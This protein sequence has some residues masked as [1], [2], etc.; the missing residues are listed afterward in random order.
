MSRKRYGGWGDDRDRLPFFQRLSTHIGLVIL[1][2]AALFFY[3]ERLARLPVSLPVL[4]SPAETP[5]SEDKPLPG[6]VV[7]QAQTD[8]TG[9]T[10]IHV[11]TQIVRAA[12]PHTTIPDRPRLEVITYTVQA[13]D[14]VFGIAE[15]FGISS[16]TLLWANGDMEYHPDDLSIGQEL[17]ILPVSGVYHQVVSGDTVEKLA[18]TYKVD[19]E[20]ILNYHLNEIGPDQELKVGQ[21]L[22]IPGGEK[23]YVPRHVS[24]YSGPIPESASKGT[25]NFGWPVT[26]Y[27]T[28]GYWHLHRAIDI[29]GPLGTPVY[30]SDSGYV[31]FA[32]WDNSGYGNLVII[33][34]GNGYTTYY[35][36]L[37]DFSVSVGD[38]VA[39]GQQIGRMGSTGRS[40]G[41][42]LHFEIRYN[43]IQRNPIG[44]LP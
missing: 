33:N 32:G 30:A 28:Q 26:G 22:I 35:A 39:K 4:A 18:Q 2:L 37:T 38:S 42:H 36:H 10:M 15:K 21:W 16:E 43:N 1:I 5:L 20:T 25:G 29:G 14:T 19:P 31:V 34:H 23:P 6:T 8:Q 17:V 12:V 41:S 13:G 11:P 9:Q 40:T 44:F 7:V 24:H 3:K 27:I